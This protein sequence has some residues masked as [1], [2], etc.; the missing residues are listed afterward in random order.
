MCFRKLQV[1]YVK[2]VE[3]QIQFNDTRPVQKRYNA[4]HR[5]LYPEVK[6]YIQDL[7]NRNL[8]TKSKSAYSSPIVA[9][10]KKNGSLRLCCDFRELNKRTIPDSHP[11]PRIQDALDSL[12]GK[13]FFSLLDQSN[14]YH[15]AYIHPDCRYMTAFVT[16]WGLYQWERIPFGLINAPAQFQRFIESCLEGLRDECVVPYLDDLLI[17]S[18]S[19]E[20]HVSH[21]KEVFKRLCKHGVKLRPEK[22][23]LFKKELRYLGRIITPYC[24]RIITPYCYRIITPY[25]YRIDPDNIAAVKKIAQQEPKTIGELRK[26]LGFLGY[27]RRFVQDFA[28]MA[29]PLYSLL[30]FHQTTPPDK[31]AGNSKPPTS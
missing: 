24:Y 10:R 15:Q 12:H 20:E 26:V 31:T 7:L 16:P 17:Y 2:E 13:K 11:L 4:I 22:C 14:A 23:E 18:N 5:P 27:F 21:S 1:T 8:I 25:G 28:R 19:F 6:N 29:K 30:K 3:M 9:V